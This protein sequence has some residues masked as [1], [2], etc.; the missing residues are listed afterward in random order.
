MSRKVLL[1]A[2][3]LVVII[4][5]LIGTGY[6]IWW[7]QYKRFAPVT[8]TRNQAE[9]Q[10]LLDKAGYVSPGRGPQAI[11]VITHRNC[12][13]CRAF[14][15]QEFPK[16]DAAGVD[17]RV[18]VFARPDDQGLRRSTAAERSTIAELWLTRSWPIYQAWFMSSDANWKATGLPVADNDFARSAVVDATRNYVSQM[19]TLLSANNVRVAYPLVIWRDQNN[20]LKVCACGDEKAY[21]FIREDLG[22]PNTISGREGPMFEIPENVMEA[23]G[24]SSSSAS[25]SAPLPAVDP[26]VPAPR[27]APAA[28]AAP[29]PAATV[30]KPAATQAVQVKK[31]ETKS[32]TQTA[33][34]ADFGPDS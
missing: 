29:M 12:D 4:P 3:A 13:T 28:K 31:T 6:W 2:M 24:A 25:K 34:P 15:E 18:I 23:F 9:I 21:H 1:W 16:F 7:D 14:Q 10:A 11:Y 26:I 33:Y 20:M 5:A 17:T 30:A 22:V 27:P 8:V 19:S 32:T